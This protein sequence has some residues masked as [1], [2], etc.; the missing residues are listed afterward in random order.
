MAQGKFKKDGLSIGRKE[1][2][3]NNIS[4]KN[5][6]NGLGG[7][8]KKEGKIAN[9]KV[10][11]TRAWGGVWKKRGP[12]RGLVGFQRRAGFAGKRA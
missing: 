6:R 2:T 3:E 5:H 4:R 12:E 7:T 11:L 8:T 9:G 10:G 1:N